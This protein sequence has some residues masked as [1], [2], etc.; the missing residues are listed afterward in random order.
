MMVSCVMLCTWPKRSAMIGD[1]LLS[2]ELQTYPH[3]ELV[4]VNDGAPLRALRD[5]VTVVNVPAG[6][7]IG[8]KRNVGLRVASGDWV[9]TWD[10][11]D[12]SW[13]ERVATLVEL[14]TQQ[15]A[16]AA[17]CNRMWITD[18][19]LVIHAL[20]PSV[21]FPTSVIWRAD[22]IAAGGYPDISYAEDGELS[23]RMRVRGMREVT[24]S[25]AMYA[26]RRHGDN[27][28]ATRE[29][30]ADNVRRMLPQAITAIPAAQQRLDS[31]L[32]RPRV[33]LVGP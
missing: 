33:T 19:E 3:R 23:A 1:A 27:V 8:A 26:H 7:T 4:V 25:A 24:C 9:A 29:N 10:D 11:D 15:G 17:R 31:L 28:T 20:T 12:F 13:P 2:Y 6:M 22:A 30:L 18:R 14:A 5:D 32:A 21:S 16:S